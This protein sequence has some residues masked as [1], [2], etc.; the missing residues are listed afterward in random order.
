M[1]N[2]S[3]ALIDNKLNTSRQRLGIPQL[4]LVQFYWND[5]GIDKYVKG[6]QYL[7][8]AQERGLVKHVGVTNFDIIRMQDMMDGGLKI[9]SSQVQYSLLDRRVENGMDQFCLQNDIKLLPF[10]V[11][12][13]GFLSER[14]LNVPVSQI[15][16][17]T[18]SKSKYASIIA[19]FGGWQWFQRL[20]QVLNQVAVKHGTTIGSVACRWVLDKPGVAGIIVGARNAD[21]V[22]DDVTLFNLGLDAED[23]QSIEEVLSEAVQPKGDI[24]TWER[25]GQW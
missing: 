3:Q 22:N 8:D 7:R 21:H 14:Y 15:K 25:G 24:Y 9:A 19:Q 17:D 2:V 4:D 20:L 5:Y 16:L 18:F 13:G 1:Y 6:A 12:A 10:G 11:L 23:Q